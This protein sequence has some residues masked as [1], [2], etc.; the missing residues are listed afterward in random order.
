MWMKS[1]YT[2]LL[3]LT[4]TTGDIT[5]SSTAT[6]Q[7]LQCWMFRH[8]TNISGHGCTSFV[9]YSGWRRLSSF[10]LL[11]GRKFLIRRRVMELLE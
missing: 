10:E 11:Y 3:L 2:L 6:N 5:D 9:S 7:I 1:V 4:E 8:W